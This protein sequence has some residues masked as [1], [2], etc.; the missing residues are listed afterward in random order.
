MTLSF[1]YCLMRRWISSAGRLSIFDKSAGVRNACSSRSFSS[2]SIFVMRSEKMVGTARFELATP[3]T[4]CK[5][6][7]RLRYVPNPNKMLLFSTSFF[8]I[9]TAFIYCTHETQP[10]RAK[11][12][13]AENSVRQSDSLRSIAHIFRAN[14]Y[15][16]QAYCPVAPDRLHC[17][18]QAPLGGFGEGR[19]AKCRASRGGGHGKNDV[20]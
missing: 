18:R 12:P 11:R 10:R 9:D 13:V 6:A 5:C 3:C 16:R 2:G 15:P 1:S 7:T 8:P 4:P 14:P 17:R 20:W 19:T